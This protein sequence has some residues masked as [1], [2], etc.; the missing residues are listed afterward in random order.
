MIKVEDLYMEFGAT[1]VLNGV[2]FE[3]KQGDVLAII[4]PSGTG[5]S[6]LLRGMNFL[7]PPKSGRITVGDVSVDAAMATKK[8]IKALREHMAMVYQTYNLF[9]NMTALQ[10]IMEALVTV[11][12]KSKKEAEQIALE[13]LEKVDMLDRKDFYPSRLSGGQQQR[14]GIARALAVKP[15]VILFDEPTS[16]LDPEMVGGVLELM[17]ELA[18]EGMTMVV[19][20]HEMG[21]AREVATKVIF[22]D[23]G[24]VRESGSPKEFFENPRD[25][26]LQEFLSKIL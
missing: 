3:I 11:H 19:V 9:K 10:N 20:T 5:K 7:V 4:G 17:K 22:M 18:G 26:R 23:E 8:Q 16:A 21:F 12:R 14:V 6:T 2:S 25:R 15:D 1:K 13:I 24:K